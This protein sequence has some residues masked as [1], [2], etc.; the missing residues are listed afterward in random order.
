VS[1]SSVRGYCANFVVSD[2]RSV[3]Y[4]LFAGRS[5]RE[6]IHDLSSAKQSQRVDLRLVNI[7]VKHHPQERQLYTAE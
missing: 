5:V 6:S 4:L 2:S 7:T 1:L 3:D